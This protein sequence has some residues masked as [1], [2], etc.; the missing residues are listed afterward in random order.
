MAEKAG[1]AERQA[2]LGSDDLG[3]DQLYRRY[4]A[5]VRR[6]IER[7]FGNGPPDPDDVVQTTFERYA[8]AERQEAVQHP[9]AFLKRMAANVVLDHRRAEKTRS[10]YA[11][12][13]RETGASARIVDGERLL[14]TRE[15]LAI[16]EQAILAMDERRRTI[17]LL[18]RVHGLSAV[19]ISRRL[20]CSQTLVKIRLAE[21]VT[22][23]QQAI[24]KKEREA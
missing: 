8:R 24:G 15:R 7:N 18:S 5:M 4:S 17:L 10:D 13:E 1:T 6:Y 20:G 12:T 16:I 14:E 19:E 3:L 2:G 11:A 23:C 9:G 22:L 21:A